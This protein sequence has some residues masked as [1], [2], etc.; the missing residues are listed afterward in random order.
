MKFVLE[1]AFPLESTVYHKLVSE[2][3]GIVTGIYVR[4]GQQPTYG[5]TWKDLKETTHLVCELTAEKSFST[6]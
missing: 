2:S 3:A 6:T 1:I 5:V 4:P